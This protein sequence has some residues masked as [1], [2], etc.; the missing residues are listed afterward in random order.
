[1]A[2]FNRNRGIPRRDESM[3]YYITMHHN[4]D[5]FVQL[6]AQH[7]YDNTSSDY[8]I[9]CGLAGINLEIDA[10]ET[11]YKNHC[12]YDITN[13]E[14]QHW[15]RMNYLFNCLAKDQT[16]HDDDLVVFIDGDAFPIETWEGKVRSELDTHAL[17]AVERR[18]DLE[19]LME[20]KWKPYPHPLFCVAKAKFWQENAIKWK[21]D[22]SRGVSTCGPLLKEW[23]EMNGHT[24]YP[25]LRTNVFNIHPLYFGVYG[26]IVYHHGASAGLDKVY[27]SSDIWTRPMLSEKYGASLDLY[28]P[29]IPMFNASM[30]KL[31]WEAIC[32]L[33]NFIKV[34]FLG[35]E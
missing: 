9:Y 27:G 33:P 1:M 30:S 4:I 24:I 3:I 29:Q 22:S 7:I 35:K 31:V 34:F 17:V 8:K 28:A 16:F 5:R 10:S 23:L 6:Q 26:D 2:E 13:I 20:E 15:F 25:L 21:L 19:P 14:N 32:Q 12:I 18:E 11:V